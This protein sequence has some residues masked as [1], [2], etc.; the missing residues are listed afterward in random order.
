MTAT[1]IF[2]WNNALMKKTR[3]LV[4]DDDPSLRKTLADILGL[5][6]YE[7][8]LAGSGAEAMA[9]M[10]Q[11]AVGVAL[12]DLMLPDMAGLEV[13]ARIKEISPLTEA[14]ILTGHAS[15]DTAIE[16]TSKGAFSYLLKPY[17][18]DTLLL[19]IR[20]G[21]ERHEAQEE[22]LR[23][24]S[25]PRLN[26]NPVIEIGPAGEVTYTNPVAERLFPDLAG[27]GLAHPLLTG[28]MEVAAGLREGNEEEAV[29]EAVIGDA[30]YE[31]HT[32]YVREIGLIRIYA[33]DITR[34]KRMEAR[35][36]EANRQL[37][38]AR[39]Q[40]LQSE[41]MAAIGLLAA[42]VAHEINNP[43]GYVNSNIGALEKYLADLFAVIEK[44]EAIEASL[45]TPALEE[46]RQLKSKVNFDFLRQDVKSLISE[47]HQG[48]ERI[49]KIILDLREFSHA[50]SE[51]K[52]VWADVHHGL[53]TTL[54][55]VWNE[56]K[57]KCDLD[58]QYGEL[59]KIWCLPSQL[60]QVFMNML[61]NAAQA[62]EVHG[63]ITI[64]TGSEGDRVWIEIS[65]T[66]KGILPENLPRIFDP[67]FTTKPVSKGVGLGLSVSYSI[68]EKHHGRIEVRSEPG[69]GA[70]FR[71]W[72]PVGPGKNTGD[73]Q[74]RFQGGPG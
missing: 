24:A 30:S 59:P 36:E 63:K 15:L 7:P 32:S 41:K 35:Q 5:K 33:L 49:K 51:D 22:I 71:I 70:T 46:L 4:V 47:S 10:A 62:I 65:D 14:I 19:N 17:Q 28:T 37:E 11:G 16:A 55:V 53:E 57:Y 58:K 25:F 34:R 73:Q 74:D 44:Y 43:V 21:V 20:H 40:L 38:Q 42:G 31:L 66:G 3:I 29:R 12:V 60:N 61:V 6:G 9:A 68:V 23:L 64:R 50:E 72:L 67:F 13:M 39:N 54:S 1:A 48:L 2:E 56:L 8:L 69:K 45:D 27:K 52:W 18:M 26:P